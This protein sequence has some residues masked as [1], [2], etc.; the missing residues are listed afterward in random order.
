MRESE[1]LYLVGLLRGAYPRQVIPDST[2]PV[3]VLGLLD[4]NRDEAMV[5]VTH[6]VRT[7]RWLPTIAEIRERVAEGAVDLPEP[8]WA[9]AEVR[10]AIGRYG[11]EQDRP[12]WSCPEI[13][14][15]VRALGWRTLCTTTNIAIER[16]RW[17]KTYTGLRRKRIERIV[18]PTGGALPG[19]LKLLPGGGGKR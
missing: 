2:E 4:L 14:D 16:E 11:L 1:A 6:L 15:A 18:A 12:A 9:W 3:Y 5:A 7:S 10:E 19:Q 13:G 17:I 8:E